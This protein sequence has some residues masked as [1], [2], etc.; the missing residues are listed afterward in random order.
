[1]LEF[2]AGAV[3]PVVSYEG[4]NYIA[5]TFDTVKEKKQ[6]FLAGEQNTSTLKLKY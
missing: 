4:I 1:M 5:M 3:E 6:V 2:N